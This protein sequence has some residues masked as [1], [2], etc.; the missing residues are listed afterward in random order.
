MRLP[1]GWE[2]S[3]RKR[4]RRQLRLIVT[5][6]NSKRAPNVLILSETIIDVVAIAKP[7]LVRGC[8]QGRLETRRARSLG[9]FRIHFRRG[10]MNRD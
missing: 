7:V 6:V 4:I 8:I 10:I 9:A 5:F 3:R 2:T 1:P